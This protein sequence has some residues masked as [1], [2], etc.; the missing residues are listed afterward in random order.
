MGKSYRDKRDKYKTND[1]YNKKNKP[2]KQDKHHPKEQYPDKSKPEWDDFNDN[3][4]R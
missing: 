4:I 1:S 3:Y 2:N